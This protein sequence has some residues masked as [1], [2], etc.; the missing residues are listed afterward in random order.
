MLQQSYV[1]TKPKLELGL[2]RNDHILNKPKNSCCDYS[3][4]ASCWDSRFGQT[5]VVLLFGLGMG[6]W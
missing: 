1:R 6:P 2:V 5:M 3:L 4:V